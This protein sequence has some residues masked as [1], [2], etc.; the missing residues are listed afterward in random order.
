MTKKQEQKDNFYVFLDFDGVLYDIEYLIMNKIKKNEKLFRYAPDS[1]E[2][3]NKLFSQLSTKYNPHLVISSFWRM[4][5]PMTVKLLK[6]HG[7]NIVGVPLMKTKISNKPMKRGLEIKGFLEEHDN[8]EN[9]I[10]IDDTSFDY[11]QHFPKE[12]IVKT[13]ILNDR[14]T[15]DKLDTALT[16][17]G[18]DGLSSG[19]EK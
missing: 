16:L 17:Y 6:D 1:I 12:K 14:L 4:K 10:I 18:F 7:F 9:F 19:M 11:A 13:H 5:F 3:L 8:S 15:E 2:T